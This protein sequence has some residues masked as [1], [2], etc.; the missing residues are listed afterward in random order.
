VLGIPARLRASMARF[1]ALNQRSHGTSFKAQP[2]TVKMH[3][4]RMLASLDSHSRAEAVAR[5][6]ESGLFSPIKLA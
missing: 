2:R 5:V 3:V 4:S 6:D 1:A